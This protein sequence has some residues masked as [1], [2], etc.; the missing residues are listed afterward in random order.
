MP[1]ISTE[2][3]RSQLDDEVKAAGPEAL[4]LYRQILA[5]GETAEWAAMC[6]LQQAPGSKNTDRAFC[7][8]ARR[9]MDKMDDYNRKKILDIAKKAGINTQG[10]CYKGGLGKYNDPAAW[11]GS[12]D[13]VIA[14]AKARKLKVEG[15]VNYDATRP[16]DEPPKRIPLSEKIIKR[17][18]LRMLKEDGRLREKMRKSP[19][20]TKREMREQIV[21]KHS[22]G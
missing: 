18:A 10:K 5:K 20:K 1:A 13:D 9:Q 11:V 21:A 6:A 12:Q 3:R 17:N 22:R 8:G 14:S 2:V 7:D 19:E 16:L 15:V 4:A